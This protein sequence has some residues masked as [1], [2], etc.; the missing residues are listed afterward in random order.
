MKIDLICISNYNMIWFL[1][2]YHACSGVRGLNI[3]GKFLK[4]I[5]I[6]VYLENNNVPWFAAGWKGK[7]F[8]E[9]MES[10]H[11]FWDIVIGE[12]NMNIVAF[13]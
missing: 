9:L 7:N 4:F 2:M 1:N 12:Y 10:D 3:E 5:A 6:G 8:N 11:F 13:K